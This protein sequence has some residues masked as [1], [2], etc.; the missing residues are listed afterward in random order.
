MKVVFLSN[1]FPDAANPNRGIYNARLVHH[2][3]RHCE[4]RVVSPRPTRGFP[5][6]WRPEKFV[7]RAEDEKF[8]PIFPPVTHIPKIGNR[9]NHKLMANSLR[10]TLR[11]LRAKF[12]FEAVLASWVYPDGCAVARLAKELHFPFVVI[13]QG[14]DVHQYLQIPVRRRIIAASLRHAAGV[15]TRS[16]E[17]GRLLCAAG[18]A[19]TSLRTIYNGVEAD[20][21]RPGDSAA[22]RQ[23]LGLD[24]AQ[25]ILLYVG[26]LLPIKNP[27][28]L[29]DAFAE[30]NRRQPQHF[31]LVLLGDGLLREE[32]LQRAD[33]LG[34][35]DRIFL[36]G[37]KTPTEVARFMQAADVLC[38]PSDNEGVPNVI[39]EAFS[40]GLRVVA[41]RVGGIPE[42]LTGDSL[43]R[44][45]ERRDAK[46]L[47]AA[48][49]ETCAQPTATDKILQ[50]AR[51]FNWE[52]TAAEHAYL[53]T[54]ATG[55]A[56]P[57]H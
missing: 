40:C 49:S 56:Q 43:G 23:Q 50:H 35:R 39:Y 42:I 37:R 54:L 52:H 27:L 36:G 31:R 16:A 21:F 46:A 28:L 4:V 32:I 13:G 20:V 29:V 38:V 51:Q 3:A 34:L 14:S 6:F 17:L 33:A 12:P 11:E 57:A 45:V 5:P 48:I 2:L 18:V 53:L 10:D 1:L 22:A 44:M 9:W 30:L 7:C 15:I 41:T 8:T 47:A 55:K 25:K 24:A 26:N 19:E